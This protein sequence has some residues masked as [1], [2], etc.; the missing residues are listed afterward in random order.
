MFKEDNQIWFYL[1]GII[2][3]FGLLFTISREIWVPLIYQEKTLDDVIPIKFAERPDFII[4]TQSDYF[5]R[6]RTNFGE[7]T[8]DLYEK[9][10]PQN[11]NNFVFLANKK[12]Y[13]QTKVHR[14]IPNLLFQMGDRN[15]L[16]DDPTNDGKGNA[17][18]F[19]EDEINWDALDLS[20]EKR[21][22]LKKD[23][24][25][26]TPGLLS[27]PL[28]RLSVAMASS[29]PNTNSSQFFIVTA[30]VDDPRIEEMNGKFTVIGKVVS[31]GDII[32][33]INS[34]PVD[35]SDPKK[36][37]PTQD[38]VILSIEIYTR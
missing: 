4:S 18:Y 23:G 30:Q 31:G 17:G 12:Y 37:T 34:V 5:A 35:N 29:G 16:D 2:I 8:I 19:I 3:M 28:E 21:E 10:A 22:K 38:I 9:R 13:N 1:I 20:Q 36:P 14:L 7:F 6:V 15:T 11:V 32:D 25:E 26:S 27:A 24:Y 33:T